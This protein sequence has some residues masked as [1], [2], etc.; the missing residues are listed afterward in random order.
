[1]QKPLLKRKKNITPPDTGGGGGKGRAF[2]Q[3][4]PAEQWTMFFS[5]RAL[6]VIGGRVQDI[7][8]PEPIIT[9]A[10]F[11]AEQ[12]R[13]SF[14]HIETALKIF[15]DDADAAK[16]FTVSKSNET[17][18]KISRDADP[19]QESIVEISH[20]AADNR[21]NTPGKINIT[22]T[23]Q[24]K[25]EALDDSL[26]L[27]V[28]AAK[29]QLDSRGSDRKDFS[30]EQCAHAPEI[31]IKLYLI[32]K[33]LGLEP[34][35][36]DKPDATITIEDSIKQ[37]STGPTAQKFTLEAADGSKTDYTLEEIYNSVR[38]GTPQDAENLLKNLKFRTPSN[39]AGIA[40]PPQRPKGV[41]PGAWKLP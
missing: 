18:Y 8:K 3:P 37:A 20:I 36:K 41:P 1:M 31:A 28:V 13:Q 32:G 23:D 30:I 15:K 16:S 34:V 35:F 19:I 26:Y 38:A 22:L 29:S 9:I 5:Q 10:P 14:N 7:P 11:T 40:P 21:K 17:T 33:S 25:T 2:H 6:N 24:N 12:F 4:P 39:T 27:M